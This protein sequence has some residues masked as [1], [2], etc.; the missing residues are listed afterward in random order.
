MHNVGGLSAWVVCSYSVF[1]LRWLLQLVA[2]SCQGES[3]SM[4]LRDMGNK[5]HLTTDWRRTRSG[6]IF[7]IG[8]T[9]AVLGNENVSAAY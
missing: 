2:S 8:E 5:A 1:H 6:G 9:A 7:E 4:P 3:Q